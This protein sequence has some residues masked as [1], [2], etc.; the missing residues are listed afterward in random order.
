MK[1]ICKETQDLG[2]PEL[3]GR[4]RYLKVAFGRLVLQV[5]EAIYTEVSGKRGWEMRWRDATPD[6]VSETVTV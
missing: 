3:T 2:I 6:D 1:C 5:E 4:R